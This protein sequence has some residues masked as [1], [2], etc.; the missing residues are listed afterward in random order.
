MFKT[1]SR[2][3][4][5]KIVCRFRFTMRDNGLQIGKGAISPR[6]STEGKYSTFGAFYYL[7][8]VVGSLFPSIAC[9]TL[10]LQITA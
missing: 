2:L 10:L 1:V 8:L 9:L 3:T 7:V 6:I 5:L 4:G